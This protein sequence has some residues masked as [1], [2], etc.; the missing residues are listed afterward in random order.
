ME[1]WSPDFSEADR[2]RI[3]RQ[4]ASIAAGPAEALMDTFDTV[5]NAIAESL[6]GAAL[7]GEVS[8]R[9]MADAVKGALNE[10]AVQDL[11]PGP[12]GAALS[13]L[14]QTAG[15]GARADGGPVTAGASY[16]VGERGPEVFTPAGAGEISSPRAANVAVTMNFAAGADARS[17]QR[18]QNQI[19]ALVA[20]AVARG[21][22][23]L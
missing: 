5:S 13:A 14:T 17:I 3:Q 9:A 22:R 12:L 6:E 16:L 7:R 23:E 4:F 1:E 21:Q 15:F 19:A 10:T 20:R 18:S 2:R 8:F 11:A